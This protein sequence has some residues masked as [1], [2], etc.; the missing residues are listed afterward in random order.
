MNNQDIFA[1]LVNVP[2]F[3]A[4]FATA[5][6]MLWLFKVIYLWVTPYKEIALIRQ[7]NR[8]AALSLL[9][10]LLGFSIALAGVIVHSVNLLDV[11]V[12]GLVALVVQILAYLSVYAMIRDIA[13]EIGAGSV[14]HGLYLGGLSLCCGVL[15]AA[16][17]TP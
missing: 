8:A 16:C 14:S 1:S 5:V 17:M 9:G 7:G 6:A 2:H 13:L 15:N 12:W 4:Y 11:L 10:A 3:L